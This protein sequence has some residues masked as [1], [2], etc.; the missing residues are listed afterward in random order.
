MTTK[1]E[2]ISL[3]NSK[4]KI[5]LEIGC[6]SR[7]KDSYA[8]GI[9][10]LNYPCV[11][12]VGD[13]FEILRLFP[14]SI[15]DEVTS[16]HFFEHIP[17]VEGLLT[18]LARILKKNGDLFITVPHFSNPYFYSDST[19]SKFFGLYTMSYFSNDEILHRKVP[20]YQRKI[21]YTLK[22]ITLS[23]K[24]SPPFYLRFIFKKLFG[25]LVNINNYTKELY[26]EMFCYFISCYEITYQLKKINSTDND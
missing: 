6:G 7:K 8:I 16:S 12:L 3:I 1:E 9:D 26:E 2:V 15:V 4:S 24:S 20:K 13:I 11:D 22:N 14:D 21:N 23:F 17:D 5:T 18:E 10:K 19:H 25:Y